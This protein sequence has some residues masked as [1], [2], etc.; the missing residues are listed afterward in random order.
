MGYGRPMQHLPP[1]IRWGRQNEDKAGRLYTENRK[2]VGEI[3]EIFWELLQMAKCFDTCCIGCIEI[4]YPYS[5]EKFITIE[6]SPDDIAK[7]FGDKFFMKR[8]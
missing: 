1:Q 5:I 6:L 7:E 3:R 4:K 8:R 2:A